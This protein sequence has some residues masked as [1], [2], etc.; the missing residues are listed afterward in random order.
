MKISVVF[1]LVYLWSLFFSAEAY[2][3]VEGNSHFW[4]EIQQVKTES[5]RFQI[6]KRALTDQREE[7]QKLSS[8]EQIK[9]YREGI[10][11][12]RA[13]DSLELASRWTIDL[14]N[15]F[16][17][18]Q[19]DY[20]QALD[21]M[22]DSKDLAERV[23]S[24]RL[25]GNLYLKL[26]AAYYNLGRFDDAI[27]FYTKAEQRFSVQDS[28]FVADA[29]F[30]R[31]QAKDY[32]G[33]FLASL[34]DYEL[35]RIYYEQLND[36]EFVDY[37]LNGISILFSKYGLREEAE[38][39]RLQLLERTNKE[40]HPR[41]WAVLMYNRSN[42][43]RKG[44]DYQKHLEILREVEE[45]LPDTFDDP[46]FQS[47]IYFQFANYYAAKK[48]FENYDKYFKLGESLQV[49]NNIQSA[50]ADM[51]ISKARLVGAIERGQR[52][53]SLRLAEQFLELIYQTDNYDY[54]LDGLELYAQALKLNDKPVQALKAF[55]DY[56][57]FKDSVFAVNQANSFAYYQTIYETERKEREL[58]NKA[59]EI[60]TITRENANKIRLLVI[61][62]SLLIV[63][64]FLLY[65]VNRLSNLKKTQQMQAQFA[66][67][68]LLSQEEE[69]KRI[70]KDLHDGLGQ[71]LLLIK[72]KV[73]LESD[74]STSNLLGSA[75]EELR[76]ISR[77][78]HPFQLEELGLTKAIGYLIDQIDESQD[79]FIDANLE[80]VDDCFQRESSLHVY[81]I[82]QEVFNNI[83]K[84][85]QA[86][87][88]RF[89]LKKQAEAVVLSIEDNGVGFDFSEK[90]NDFKSL[91]LKTLKE[92]TAAVS[93]SL[94]VES[95]KG[96]GTKFT[97]QFPCT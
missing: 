19:Y 14:F 51:S 69:R 36:P 56:H 18:R 31:A 49:E 44:G 71:S 96:K 8:E 11:T 41:E 88:V 28:I 30:F 38:K 29:I 84:H 61:V 73:A 43:F 20:E 63:A 58:L 5:E 64:F 4:E 91:G 76:G 93:G 27:N 1:C 85:S 66:Q 7:V 75:I 92:R 46:S 70:S 82:V 79:I 21:L 48:D 39:I 86:E 62:A 78:L 68:L 60:D 13:L 3:Q 95:E 12:A 72:N 54:R 89:N 32:K 40:T 94:K 81:R 67:D 90:Y 2:T 6:F 17:N 23:P 65:L 9:V 35:A 34:K 10:V 77:S 15:F 25:G 50:F 52:E 74:S 80:D 97:F 42:D 26:A 37:V 53:R 33:M 16:E 47:L 87:G 83:L 45:I 22:L 59:I 57:A 24:T 55:E